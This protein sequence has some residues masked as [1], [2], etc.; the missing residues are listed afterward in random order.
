MNIILIIVGL[1][2]LIKGADFLIDAASNIARKFKIS[3]FIIGLTVIAVGTS[4]PELMVSIKS[5]L[6]GH[7]SLVVGNIVGSCIYNLLLILGIM[8]LLKPIKIK[9]ESNIILMLF[10]ILAVGM[11]GNMYGEITKPEGIMLLLLFGIFILSTFRGEGN[12][13]R[14]AQSSIV[15]SIFFLVLGI[16]LLKYG[17]DLVVDN[18]SKLGQKL[19][20]SEK[21]IGI[22]IVALGT[23]LPELVTSIVAVRKNTMQIA[24]GNII[25]SN[26]FNLLLVLGVTSLIKPV[27]FSSD[28]NFDLLFLSI[29]TLIVI[30]ACLKNQNEEIRRKEGIILIAFFILYNIRLFVI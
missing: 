10:S 20:I 6:D 2:F 22:T 17:G 7:Y 26:I 13:D 4:L 15:K 18:A 21:I 1:F 5:I 25:G 8:S 30:I 11:F 9:K 23:S 12:D 19:N 24:V 16:I 3:E 29:V 27:E 28:Y 14:P